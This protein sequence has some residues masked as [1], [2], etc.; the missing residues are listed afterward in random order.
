MSSLVVPIEIS[1]LVLDAERKVI[2]PDLDFARLPWASADRDHNPDT[3]NLASAASPQPFRERFL[4]LSRGVHL[5]WSLPDGLTKGYNQAKIWAKEPVD[6]LFF[7]AI[8]NRWALVRRR[9]GQITGSWLIESD[10]INPATKRS[11]Q[12]DDTDDQPIT[13]P[14]PAPMEQG[15]PFL[16]L[17]RA[18]SLKDLLRRGARRDHYLPEKGVALTALGFGN[19]SFAALYANCRSVL[20]HHDTEVPEDACTYEVFGWHSND[21][22]D[23]LAAFRQHLSH[24]P[25]DVLIDRLNASDGAE[26]KLASEDDLTDALIQEAHHLLLRDAFGWSVGDTIPDRVLCHGQLVVNPKEDDLNAH[27]TSI[28]EPVS[29]GHSGVE[30][31]GSLLAELLGDQPDRYSKHIVEEQLEALRLQHTYRDHALD[32]DRKFKESRHTHQFRSAKRQRLWAVRPIEEEGAVQATR[33]SEDLPAEIAAALNRLNAAQHD[34]DM[35]AAEV[36][37]LRQA[38]FDDWAMWMQARYRRDNHRGFRIDVNAA[39]RLIERDLGVLTARAADLGV[40]HTG[41]ADGRWTIA[42]DDGDAPHTKAQRVHYHYAVVHA[43]IDAHVNA[44]THQRDLHLVPAPGPRF[45]KAKDPAILL[46][47]PLAR[48]GTRHGHDGVLDCAHLSAEPRKLGPEAVLRGEL[49][50]KLASD[51]ENQ[52]NVLK[53]DAQGRSVWTPFMMAWQAE[54]AMEAPSQNGNLTSYPSDFIAG[55]YKLALE[56]TD[57]APNDASAVPNTHPVSITG[58][59]VLIPKAETHLRDQI[60]GYLGRARGAAARHAVAHAETLGLPVDLQ[61]AVE[62]FW[63]REAGED[64]KDRQLAKAAADRGD[65][66]DDPLSTVL[67]AYK[68]VHE[69]HLTTLSQTL[70]GFNDALM[71]HHNELQLPIADPLGFEPEQIL[72]KRVRAAVGNLHHTSPNTQIMFNPLVAGSVRLQHLRVIDNFGKFIDW[73]PSH[74]ITSETVAHP[75]GDYA[76]LLPRFAQ[77][78]RLAADWISASDDQIELTGQAPASPVCGWIMSGRM[79]HGT[80][81]LHDET[82]RGLG[83]IDEHGKWHTVPGEERTVQGPEFIRNPHMAAVA[84]WLSHRHKEDGFM[85][86]FTR[87]VDD[88]LDSICPIDLDDPN[89]RALFSGRPMAV[90]RARI[91]LELLGGVATSISWADLIARINGNAPSS[92]DF[93]GIRVPLRIGEHGLLGDGVVGFWIETA[94]GDGPSRAYAQSRFWTP[95]VKG[96][97]A[98]QGHPDIGHLDQAK[99]HPKELYLSPNQSDIFVTMLLDPRASAHFTTGVLPVKSLRLTP[100]HYRDAMGRI[101]VSIT[102]MPVLGPEGR[103]EMPVPVQSGGQ[104]VWIERHPGAWHETPAAPHVARDDFLKAYPASG[105]ALWRKLVDAEWLVTD[106]DMRPAEFRPP[107]LEK[108]P[109][110]EGETPDSIAALLG[111]LNQI[112]IRISKPSR[113]K[114][115]NSPTVATEGW[116][117][118][119]PSTE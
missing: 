38:L 110:L 36:D 41:L 55:N 15:Q 69:H 83:Q 99:A 17:G 6:G 80:L 24:L 31:M 3:P 97:R 101:G 47:H 88:A 108:T 68:L 61:E 63:Q 51:M 95:Q 107:D 81:S 34:Y 66:P 98:T 23:P 62:A 32:I 106:D 26:V 91:R 27:I 49:S 39:A 10:Y 18:Q 56:G 67:A 112:A 58:R 116:L 60:I 29:F 94:D 84:H 111:T 16:R 22:T 13:Y 7:P 90:V 21:I 70:G 119:R 53:R 71:G 74:L 8:P 2:G 82:G 104:W 103:P 48:P 20:G 109:T 12:P 40:L 25:A 117:Q 44:H 75:K 33:R 85:R 73:H 72:T 79:D 28:S 100:A 96:T 46:T 45:W 92:H 64:D 78:A 43:L 11:A 102:A 50:A 1:A 30:A 115:F 93:E 65:L 89:T 113:H 114:D 54:V 59:C 4:R 5:H 57:L 105:D 52:R 14:D 37:R 77:P 76:R 86:D 9:D 118:F 19:P 42:T 35:G 87:T